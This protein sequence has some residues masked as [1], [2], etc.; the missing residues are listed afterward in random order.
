MNEIQET[1]RVEAFY[2]VYFSKNPN[3]VLGISGKTSNSIPA[4]SARESFVTTK[5]KG[6][7]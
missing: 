6:M 7:D 1:K 3:S 4:L 5:A 2:L